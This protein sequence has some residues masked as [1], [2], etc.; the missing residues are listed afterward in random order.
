MNI[1]L[2]EYNENKS[3]HEGLSFIVDGRFNYKEQIFKNCV[4]NFID[5]STLE[6][7]NCTFVNCNFVGS[8][9]TIY[10]LS[11]CSLKLTKCEKIEN[12]KIQ[13]YFRKID[14][15]HSLANNLVCSAFIV[16]F[17]IFVSEV[18]DFFFKGKCKNLDLSHSYFSSH[19]RKDSIW[20]IK[21]EKS[22]NCPKTIFHMVEV[23]P[24]YLATKCDDKSS[25]DLTSAWLVDD[26]SRL[27]KHYSGVSLF[28]VFLL[29]FVFFLPLFTQSYFLILS[30]KID[31][32]VLNIK[33]IPLWE[34]ILFGGKEGLKAVI[35][36]LM[37]IILFTYNS[38][39]I[40]MTIS[41]SKLR[42]E[43]KFLGD[44]NFQLVSIHPEKYRFQ[45]LIDKVLNYLFYIA[46]IY[47]VLK[48]WDTLQILVP[49]FT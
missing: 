3:D 2:S 20:D 15:L 1:A 49:D 25:L 42:E 4:F 29:S 7:E 9:N 24:F 12:C 13:K 5:S 21:I 37:T 34:S 11:T 35:Y 36:C 30:S 47:G 46:L 43:E 14:I 16:D 41:I 10:T 39:R 8:E 28:I 27:R 26:W 17:K 32:S 18:T 45:I 31:P 19:K 44:S 40:Y 33:Q 38:L 23:N 22:A 48:L 6:F